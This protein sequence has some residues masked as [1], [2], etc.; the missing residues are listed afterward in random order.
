MGTQSSPQGPPGCPD[1]NLENVVWSVFAIIITTWN[2][3]TEKQNQNNR[4]KISKTNQNHGC[5]R[6][7]SGRPAC[8]GPAPSAR[9]WWTC[10]LKRRKWKCKIHWT[11]RRF[12]TV[13]STE[14][15]APLMVGPQVAWML[16]ASWGRSGKQE[17]EQNS[18]WGPPISGA[19]YIVVL[20]F[21]SIRLH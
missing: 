17:Q 19:L 6:Q 11:L 5:R 21:A 16:R 4:M 9:P 14:C 13:Q 3:R 20:H 2:V 15:K 18:T 12:Y 10:S 7:R 8:S 1:Q